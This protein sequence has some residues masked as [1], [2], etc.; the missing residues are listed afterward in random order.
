[1]AAVAPPTPAPQ[2]NPYSTSQLTASLPQYQTQ[3]QTIAAH[4]PLLES[5]KQY[6]TTGQN[7]EHI[8]TSELQQ[9][10]E[11]ATSGGRS[12]L[13]TFLSSCHSDRMPVWDSVMSMKGRISMSKILFEFS[14]K[15]QEIGIPYVVSGTGLKIFRPWSGEVEYVFFKKQLPRLYLS[16]MLN[17][18]KWKTLL[19]RP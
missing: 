13:E 10:F 4:D 9:I 1:M 7:A 2:P 8:T 5:L 3:T 15:V 16:A 6:I 19:P 11:G 12:V 18:T 14:L 17:T